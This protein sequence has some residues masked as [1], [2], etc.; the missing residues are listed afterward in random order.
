MKRR[1]TIMK[2]E[3]QTLV[4]S[5]EDLQRKREKIQHDLQT[6]ESLV[7]CMEG[8]LS[9][10]KASL[11]T[12]TSKNHQLKGDLERTEQELG[13]AQHRAEK[14]QAENS[15]LQEASNHQRQELEG[16]TEKI[17]NLQ[18]EIKKLQFDLERG[19]SQEYT[20]SRRHGS[21]SSSDD[22]SSH[23][24]KKIT[25]LESQRDRDAAEFNRVNTELK[26]L[27]QKL[28]EKQA[29]SSPATPAKSNVAVSFDL[30]SLGSPAAPVST[31]HTRSQSKQ[32]RD[33]F[34]TPPPPP[35]AQVD[36]TELIR[37]QGLLQESK[38]QT[39]GTPEPPPAGPG[40][41]AVGLHEPGRGAVAAH[42]TRFCTI[43]GALR[44][45]TGSMAVHGQDQTDSYMCDRGS[46]NKQ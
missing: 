27:K 30:V 22:E 24:K 23:L 40:S 42:C 39:E 8:Q 6:K 17:K 37:L 28:N 44:S 12:E 45:L 31:P 5:C 25:D 46:A 2:R 34:G 35:A 11:D 20:G 36:N 15:H 18:Q 19:R 14:L 1:V 32:L 13:R 38:K 29:A 21:G 3:N 4:E 9:H 10:A 26:H 43:L 41:Q 33:P 16:K 7:S